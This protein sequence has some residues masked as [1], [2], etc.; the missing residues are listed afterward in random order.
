MK[1]FAQMA[2]VSTAKPKTVL[3]LWLV[4]LCIFAAG[5]TNMGF[6]ADH[7]I[8]FAEENALLIAHENIERAFSKN[9]NVLFV[10]SSEQENDT[11][12]LLQA[13]AKLTD[14]AWYMPFIRR[15]DS[16]TNFQHSYAE[17]DT[18]NV[19]SLLDPYT[20]LDQGYANRIIQTAMAEPLRRN[21]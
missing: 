8:F 1:L 11:L 10:L 9:D 17:D 19:E 5:L 13:S 2:A 4:V 6:R 21:R 16:V 7:K 15:V 20:Q 18:V 12:R 14:A 3:S